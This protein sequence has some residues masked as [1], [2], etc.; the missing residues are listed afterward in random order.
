MKIFVAGAT[1]AIGRPLITQLLA[2][3]HEVAALTRS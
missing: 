1:G 3:G 2:Q